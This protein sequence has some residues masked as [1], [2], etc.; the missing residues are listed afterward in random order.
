MSGDYQD[1][2]VKLGWMTDRETRS[3]IYSPAA[4]YD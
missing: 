3:S 1:S 2:K 4:S